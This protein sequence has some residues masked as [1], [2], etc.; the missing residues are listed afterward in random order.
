MESG[1]YWL[2]VNEQAIVRFAEP[3]NPGFVF[4]LRRRF[5]ARAVSH[6]GERVYLYRR[7]PF[8]ESELEELYWEIEYRQQ[9]VG[10]RVQTESVGVFTASPRR[11]PRRPCGPCRESS[12]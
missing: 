4:W 2:K 7:E 6:G 8:S 3:M 5:A 12:S 1:R 9:R 10:K 11:R